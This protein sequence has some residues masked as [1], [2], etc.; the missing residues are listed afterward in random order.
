MGISLSEIILIFLV[1]IIFFKPKH[2][3]KFSYKMG[4]LY[5]ILIKKLVK[6]KNQSKL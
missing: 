2:I 5:H 1:I 4:R 3:S 6:I